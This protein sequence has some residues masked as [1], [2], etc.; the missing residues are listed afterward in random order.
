MQCYND[1]G[2]DFDCGH[3]SP[4]KLYVHNTL[5]VSHS[6]NRRMAK[7]MNNGDFFYENPIIEIKVFPIFSL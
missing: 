6:V 2:Q 4:Y 1:S 7:C 3:R 5:L